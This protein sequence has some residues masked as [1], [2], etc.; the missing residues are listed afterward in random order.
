V[1]EKSGAYY[2]R[3]AGDQSVL[4]LDPAKSAELVKKFSEL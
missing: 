2:A 4:K 1:G 3:R